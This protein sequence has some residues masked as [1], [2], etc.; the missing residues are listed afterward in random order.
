M[1]TKRAKQREFFSIEQANAMLPL[2]RVIVAD[3]A[4]LT[5]EVTDRRQRIS[6]LL[7]GRNP[8]EH[9]LYREELVQVEGELEKDIRRLHDYREELRA[10]G[11]ESDNRP[12]GLVDFPALIDGRKVRLCWKL[13]EG[14]ILYWHDLDEGCSARQL[15]TADSMAGGANDQTL[16]SQ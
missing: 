3:L 2:V 8:N 12:E 11:V 1:T 14:E 13:G 9:D 5:R 7:S 4:E 16:N 10:L 15:L 6:F